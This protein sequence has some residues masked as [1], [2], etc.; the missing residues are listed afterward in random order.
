M[1]KYFLLYLLSMFPVLSSPLQPKPILQAVVDSI[2]LGN[3]V[4]CIATILA[5]CVPLVMQQL[6]R[7]QIT[8][9]IIHDIPIKAVNGLFRIIIIEL[10]NTGN[11]NI[12]EQ[13]FSYPVEID[14]KGRTLASGVLPEIEQDAMVI[15]TGIHSQ[16]FTIAGDKIKLGLFLFQKREKFSVK[17]IVR[18]GVRCDPITVDARIDS[19]QVRR[20]MKRLHRNIRDIFRDSLIFFAALWWLSFMISRW[21]P[22]DESIRTLI[23]VLVSTVVFT[24]FVIWRTIRREK[25]K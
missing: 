23:F 7:K 3:I 6:V 1:Q 13:D 22:Y 18:D 12:T 5:A 16:F 8:Y 15:P 9:D 19:G 24:V 4:V 20:R 10:V 14:L 21:H 25:G 17:C 11:K 2:G